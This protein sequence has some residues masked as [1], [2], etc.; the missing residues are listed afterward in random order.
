[1]KEY[2]VYDLEATCE[3]RL[4]D[5]NFKKEI[6]E[7]GAVKINEN[8]EIIDTFQIFVKPTSTKV[9]KFC[10]DLT[11]IIADDLESASFFKS[12]YVEFINWSLKNTS[13]IIF[14]S[15]G[16][17][18]KYQII[19]ECRLN[20][21]NSFITNENHKNL[22]FLYFTQMGLRRKVGIKKALNR[23]NIKL[24]GS[25]HRALDDAL[26]TSKIFLKY[27]NTWGKG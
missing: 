8:A 10:T 15:W 20:G 14:L 18:D 21:L 5:P 26:N 1:M 23:E 3:D 17:F 11:G 25:H 4:V 16:D 27:F 12:S 24:E 13:N 2:I 22:S 7:I 19:K 9:T 6:I